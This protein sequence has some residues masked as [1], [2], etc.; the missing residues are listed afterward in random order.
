MGD[1]FGKEMESAFRDDLHD[2]NE[3]LLAQ[4][5]QR[6]L[7]QRFKDSLARLLSYWL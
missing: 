3:I 6:P 1:A 4:W 5:K 7:A 2:S